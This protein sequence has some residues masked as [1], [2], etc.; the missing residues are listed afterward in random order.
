M[1][2]KE[3]SVL[4]A[5]E[6]SDE[7]ATNAAEEQAP[8]PAS[9]LIEFPGSGR[10][11]PWRKELS[12]RVREIQQRRAREAALEA[13]EA[14]RREGLPVPTQSPL[15]GQTAAQSAHQLG[16]VP[17][18]ETPEPNPIVVAA[19]RRLERAR[20][21]QETPTAQVSTP[22]LAPRPVAPPKRETRTAQARVA[23]GRERTPA[24][25]DARTKPL[26]PSPPRAPQTSATTGAGTKKD[27]T[28]PTSQQTTKSEEVVNNA[29]TLEK[30]EILLAAAERAQRLLTLPTTTT[31][32]TEASAPLDTNSLEK[33][34]APKVDSNDAPKSEATTTAAAA[35]FDAG[36]IELPTVADATPPAESDAASSFETPAAR[37]RATKPV[38]DDSWLSR[39]EAEILPKAQTAQ[40]TPDDTAPTLPRI[41]AAAIDLLLVSF[42]SS[43]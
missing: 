8:P 41:A 31:P 4:V 37:L 11:P 18:P 26:P 22:T 40:R 6:L 7:Q 36:S 33:S 25:S 34:V 13:E 10:L 35:T 42:L 24:E 15:P 3:K 12:E 21:H 29:D 1:T 28:S 9:T 30:D 14:A 43:P 27:E 32:A 19:L 39:L 23:N 2:K 20:R 38:I 17:Q 16:L 5:D